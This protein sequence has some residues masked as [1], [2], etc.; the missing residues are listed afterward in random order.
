MLWKAR[1]AQPKNVQGLHNMS[2]VAPVQ[3][4]QHKAGT[5]WEHSGA[6][7]SSTEASGRYEGEIAEIHQKY[8][9]DIPEV[10]RTKAL[11]TPCQHPGIPPATRLAAPTGIGRIPSAKGTRPR[12]GRRGRAKPGRGTGTPAGTPRCSRRPLPVGRHR[13]PAPTARGSQRA[14]L[15]IKSLAHRSLRRHSFGGLCK[16]W[17]AFENTPRHHRGQRLALRPALAR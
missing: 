7:Q 6:A 17:V 9:G 11:S 13:G 3:L 5:R 1:A 15:G 14:R 12:P 4:C 10:H 16:K 8:T 2:T